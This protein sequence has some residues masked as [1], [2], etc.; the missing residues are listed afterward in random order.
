LQV[1]KG[2]IDFKSEPWPKISEA[3]KDCVRKLLEMD[4]SKRASSEQVRCCQHTAQSDRL[5]PHHI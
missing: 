2:Q 5:A 1:L 3:A 4:P